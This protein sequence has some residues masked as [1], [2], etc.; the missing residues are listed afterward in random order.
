MSKPK[1]KTCYL[2]RYFTKQDQNE[3]TADQQVTESSDEQVK[4]Y[5]EDLN[6][7][8]DNQ[9]EEIK[10]QK[11]I[12]LSLLSFFKEKKKSEKRVKELLEKVMKKD[13]KTGDI[14]IKPDNLLP[15]RAF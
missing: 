14:T 13:K 7:S 10:N 5:L 9:D 11:I 1:N 6:L 8:S 15:K 3:L 12:R 2:K 4:K